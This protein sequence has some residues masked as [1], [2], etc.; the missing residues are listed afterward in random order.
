[1]NIIKHA[2]LILPIIII[3]FI[4]EKEPI[5]AEEERT[6]Y[7][8]SL[9]EA[10]DIQKNSEGTPMTSQYKYNDAYVLWEDIDLIES[11]DARKPFVNLYEEPS[12]SAKVKATSQV[13]FSQIVDFVYGN[14]QNTSNLWFEVK[15][16]EGKF[17]VHHSEMPFIKVRIKKDG[18]VY[19]GPNESS[20][21]YGD[22]L[23]D[24]EYYIKDMEEGFLSIFYNPWRRAKEED[25][26]ASLASKQKWQHIRLDKL[27]HVSVDEIN[28][29]L[30][31]KGILQDEG[32]AFKKGAEKA[33]INESYLIAHAFLETGHG[34]SP[35]SNGIEVGLNEAGESVLADD[36]NKND[37]ADIKTVYNMF[38]IEAVDSCP[39]ECGAIKAY[40][41][42]WTEPSI[43]IEEGASWI[44]GEYI[45]NE[46]K[47]NTLYKMR[48][49]P[50][51]K[52]G[53]AWKQYA[54][55]IDWSVKQSKLI[56]D[57][58]KAWDHPDLTYDY[59]KFK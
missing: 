46:F 42:G 11:I 5:F 39:V 44:G 14:E 15:T 13:R 31:G 19:E 32:E 59:P 10:V 20:H 47:Q 18:S 49:N 16:N 24:E 56:E 43:A 36:H 53:S 6:N 33:G 51:M 57:I 12:R 58:L 23:E 48:W 7:G 38:G 50:D 52:N 30:E 2:L 55:D 28:E 8:I 22:V 35:L 9:E 17:Y 4:F 40:E 3:G 34:T 41:E 37:L 29:V 27:T 1:M 54:T 25:I 45:Y 26:A 21:K